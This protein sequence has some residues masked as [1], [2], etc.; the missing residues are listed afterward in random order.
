MQNRALEEDTA[1]ESSKCH[2]VSVLHSLKV[3][4]PERTLAQRFGDAVLETQPKDRITVDGNNRQ[5][6]AKGRLSRL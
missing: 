2:L 6:V 5:P 4:G 3:A 1:A